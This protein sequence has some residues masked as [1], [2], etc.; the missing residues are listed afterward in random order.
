MA[1]PLSN[2]L[3]T[4][5]KHAGFSEREVALLLGCRDASRISRYE[6]FHRCPPLEIAL[7]YEALFHTSVRELFTGFYRKVARETASRAQALT[8]RLASERS[9]RLVARKLTALKAVTESSATIPG[10][11]AR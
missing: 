6:S 9:T 8:E 10:G 5:R 3:R 4:H 2:Y 11:H 7:A 1:Q